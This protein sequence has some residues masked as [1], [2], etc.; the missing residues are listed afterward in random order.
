M[1]TTGGVFVTV[2]DATAVLVE[3]FA[4]VIEAVIVCVPFDRRRVKV[5]PLPIAPSLLDVQAIEP[6]R[7]PWSKSLATPVNWI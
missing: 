7:L 1:L 6:V 3:P 2:I 4:S 5:P